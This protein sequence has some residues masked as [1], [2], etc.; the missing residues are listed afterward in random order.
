MGRRDREGQAP[1]LDGV[2]DVLGIAFILAMAVFGCIR[3]FVMLL[4]YF[5]RCINSAMIVFSSAKRKFRDVLLKM[6]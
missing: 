5:P 1:A 3:V 6:N 2:V 4:C